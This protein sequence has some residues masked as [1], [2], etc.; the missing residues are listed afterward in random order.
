[1]TGLGQEWPNTNWSL[2]IDAPQRKAFAP[3][4]ILGVDKS[5]FECK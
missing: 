3:L 5:N 2:A 4:A 1:M